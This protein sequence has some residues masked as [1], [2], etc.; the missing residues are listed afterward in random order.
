MWSRLSAL[1]I[2]GS[3]VLTLGCDGVTLDDWDPTDVVS[4]L[5]DVGPLVE[6]VGAAAHD[7]GATI[8]DGGP[9]A[10]VEL[11]SD[12]V[13]P[14]LTLPLAAGEVRAGVVLDQAAL[15]TGPKAEALVGDVKVYNAHVAFMIEGARIASGYRHRGGYPVDMAALDADGVPSQDYFGELFLGG[16]LDIL[17]PESVEVMDDGVASGE[18]WVRVTG[19]TGPFEFADSFIADILGATDLQLEMALD[20]RLGPDDRALRLDVTYTNPTS[21]YAEVDLAA[22]MSH[23]GDGAWLWAPG[24]GFDAESA[25]I[26]VPYYGTSGSRLA[27][28]VMVAEDD[29]T[30]LFSY[31]GVTILLQDG[32]LV[33][34]GESVARTMWF[35]VT[36]NG[37]AGLDAMRRELLGSAAELGSVA[38]MVALPDTAAPGAE[39]FVAVRRAD[40]APETIAPVQADGS[41]GFELEVGAYSVTAYLQGHVPSAVVGI[42]VLAGAEVSPQL[43]IDA[44]ARVVVTVTDPAD[45]GAAVPARVTFTR[46]GDTPS[47]WPP[48]D[49]RPQKKSWSGG[50]SA[51]ALVTGPEEVVLVPAGTYN[52][53]AGRGY[54]YERDVRDIT[55]VAGENAPLELVVERVIDTT[56]WLSADFHI[57][58]LRSPDSYVPY[59]IRARQAASD[60]LDL[61]ILTEHVYVAGLGGAIDAAGIGDEVIGVV[62]QEVTT[63]AYG[64]FNAFPLVWDPLKPNL[65]GVFPYDKD[66]PE[67]F[68]AIRAQS[69]GDEIIAVNHP[70]GV[71]PGAYFSWVG[72]NAA[73]DTVYNDAGWST[74]WDAIEVFNGSCS[75]GGDNGDTLKDWIALTNNGYTKTLGSGSDTHSESTPPGKV[76]NWIRVEEAAVRES[77]E[78][79]VPAVRGRRLFVSCGPFVRFTAEVTG[80]EPVGLGG[81]VAVDGDGEATLHATVEAPTWMNVTEAR[82]WENGVVVDVFDLTGSADPVV[83]FDSD[84]TISPD[85]DA[86]YAL[87]VVGS[88]S[89]H[90]IGGGSPYALTNPIEVDADGDGEWTAP[91]N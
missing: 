14:D 59:D 39:A 20:Y 36:D 37:P 13:P 12:P 78:N 34:A 87:E 55:L 70:R 64:H 63:F 65:G 18:A 8:E 2:L 49:V 32:F 15:L 74:N 73:E 58:A 84:L 9:V 11:P 86:W 66:A 82:L 72:L 1:L 47:P 35:G 56:G 76:R 89:L 75:T 71:G 17:W 80:G 69:P 68:A 48:G 10:D 29:L 42:D 54:S 83:R 40:G 53:V 4:G 60:D 85:A 79:L 91:G 41:F 26:P 51:V 88:G 24:V 23:S 27:Y 61:P 19:E 33:P 57:H 28:G 6:D 62:G 30:L 3:S 52:I 25:A 21:K 43:A 5:A 81:R 7:A 38:G 50:T 46:T 44:A 16:N 77:P 22:S 45:G 90:P 31:S 67:L